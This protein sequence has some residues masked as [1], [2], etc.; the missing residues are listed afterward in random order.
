MGSK[1]EPRPRLRLPEELKDKWLE[2]YS[3]LSH[4]AIA[5]KINQFID[6]QMV[7]EYEFIP[8]ILRTKSHQERLN[9]D[10][11]AR[12]QHASIERFTPIQYGNGT[13]AVPDKPMVNR[14]INSRTIGR[15]YNEKS[16]SI[17]T[18]YIIAA[19]SGCSREE[20]DSIVNLQQNESYSYR[21]LL[22]KGWDFYYYHSLEGKDYVIKTGLFLERMK[23][24]H[25]IG[26]HLKFGDKQLKGV[27]EILKDDQVL[28]IKIEEA[29]IRIYLAFTLP[30]KTEKKLVD[31][32]L[33]NGNGIITEGKN[34]VASGNVV[35]NKNKIREKS[36][37]L[38]NAQRVIRYIGN[39]SLEDHIVAFFL[40]NKDKKTKLI[41]PAKK[42]GLTYINEKA[43]KKAKRGDYFELK[44]LFQRD[45]N[46]DC[47]WYSFSR[48][49]PERY[50]ITIF[51]WDL[52][53]KDEEQAVK[54]SRRRYRKEGGTHYTGEFLLD[55]FKLYAHLEQTEKKNISYKSFSAIIGSY[56][57]TQILG[58]SSTMSYSRV[59]GESRN[60]A[61]REIL[62]YLPHAT[63]E[64]KDIENGLLTYSKFIS[65]KVTKTIKKEH[66]LYIASR[67]QS[68]LSFPS[69]ENF[70]KRYARIKEASKFLGNYY[71]LLRYKRNTKQ[72]MLMILTLV[73]DA[74]SNVVMKVSYENGMDAIYYGYAE[75]YSNNLHI[76]L[77][78]D[79][80]NSNE[81]KIA[82][83][84]VNAER[85]K[86]ENEDTQ[87]NNLP[88]KFSGVCIDTD[89]S[90]EAGAYP[91]VMLRKEIMSYPDKAPDIISVDKIHPDNYSSVIPER[92]QM[93]T[94]QNYFFEL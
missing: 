55:G 11:K 65:L 14:Y 90:D 77:E 26:A 12:D 62:C 41:H 13:Y 59:E 31:K 8:V 37:I 85:I 27:A 79:T 21:D 57:D 52:T 3:D 48:I 94:P 2:D 72:K 71:I 29:R 36:V 24:G 63:F 84:I 80:N 35:M 68:T 93:T 54:V 76:H 87:K 75:H 70:K 74:L 17:E 32:W 15:I 33:I 25:S 18:R 60:V 23:D 50:G 9:R 53:F 34:S 78:T 81:Q 43:F 73:I 56:E 92:F 28:I 4:E 22:A 91:F 46:L 16:V 86:N 40:N 64:E 61:L 38:R 5:K 88:D 1:K 82:T 20:A 45:G 83:L 69:E 6:D 58:I 42:K 10:K 67:S 44:S 39:S 7:D 89:F 66:P 49:K 19:F 47:G 30:R 51:H